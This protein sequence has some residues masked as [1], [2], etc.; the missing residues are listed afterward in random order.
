M[1]SIPTSKVLPMV[2]FASII[3]TALTIVFVSPSAGAV[4]FHGVN[5][6]S[7]IGADGKKRIINVVIDEKELLDSYDFWK[8]KGL[9]RETTETFFSLASLFNGG[10]VCSQFCESGVARS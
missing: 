8:G 6:K 9:R 1:K 3:V 4:D 2:H 5:I 10:R 7:D